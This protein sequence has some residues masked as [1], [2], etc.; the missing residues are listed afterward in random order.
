M[1]S[2]PPLGFDCSGQPS[3]IAVD[4]FIK[5]INAYGLTYRGLK[6]LKDYAGTNLYLSNP[7]D[8]N[9]D[10]KVGASDML[11][12]LN[13]YGAVIN[14]DDYAIYPSIYEEVSEFRNNNSLEPVESSYGY[15]DKNNIPL[16]PVPSTGT[17]ESKNSYRLLHS[18]AQS[19]MTKSQLQYV[20]KALYNYIDN[21]SWN[22]EENILTKWF[23][24]GRVSTT[25]P[26]E[27]SNLNEDRSTGLKKVFATATASGGQLAIGTD[28]LL[29]TLQYYTPASG[30][31]PDPVFNDD[32]LVFSYNI[33]AYGAALNPSGAT[34][35]AEGS[36]LPPGGTGIT[37]TGGLLDFLVQNA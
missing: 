19:E 24:R 32:S 31:I 10:G 7:Y 15:V 25:T 16:P 2:F 33:S 11:Y 3:G 6:L 8:Y 18:I 36:V 20:I 5:H 27:F 9:R 22:Q 29:N 21:P 35:F 23:E 17:E 4:D 34:G 26:P 14:P 12:I 30:P 37:T 13:A 1:C 28:Q